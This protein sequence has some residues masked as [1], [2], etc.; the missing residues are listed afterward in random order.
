M[1]KSL[2]ISIIFISVAIIVTGIGVWRHHYLNIMNAEPEKM[3]IGTLSEPNT[4]PD[5][6]ETSKVTPMESDSSTNV[7]KDGNIG[8]EKD[9]VIATQRIDK[10]IPPE[11]IE[12]TRNSYVDTIFGDIAEQD[13]LPEVLAALKK[14][15]ELQSEQTDIEAELKQLL[16][17]ESYD[18]DA[19]N[20]ITEKLN[21]LN[22]QRIDALE[23]LAP[24]SQEAFNILQATIAR[25][26]AAAE[27]SSG[28]E[29]KLNGLK[30]TIQKLNELQESFPTM[31]REELMQVLDELEVIIKEQSKSQR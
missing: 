9:D 8:V 23:T 4:L 3:Y 25:K 15:K 18:W 2:R 30:G 28:F 29:D 19:I 27:V 13:L 7:K 6:T 10:S 11:T 16:E 26:I 14:Y 5:K 12:N 17:T 20:L 21:T 31:S 22:Q 1:K 24:Y